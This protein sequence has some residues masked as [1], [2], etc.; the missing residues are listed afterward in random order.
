MD[1]QPGL[2]RVGSLAHREGHTKLAASDN[3]AL[4]SSREAAGR[5]HVS[6]SVVLMRITAL[7]SIE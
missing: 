2:I 5:Q 6:L 7:G 4:C 1:A 3:A